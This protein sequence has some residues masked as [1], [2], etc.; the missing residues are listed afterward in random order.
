MRYPAIVIV[1]VALV[2]VA[3]CGEHKS[4]AASGVN[5]SQAA[6]LQSYS[7]QEAKVGDRVV[8]PV[9]RN[10]FAVTSS[11]LFVNAQGK[12]VYV[13]CADCKD[14]IEKT[15]DQYLKVGTN[16]AVDHSG[17]KM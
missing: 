15:P 2:F 1:I 7:A 17:M 11:S 5:A 4:H 12:K 16:T 14:P 3:A 13:C 10:T 9:T 8:C 6:L